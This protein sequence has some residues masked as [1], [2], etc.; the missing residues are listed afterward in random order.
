[1]S[2]FEGWFQL[3][4][5]QDLLKKLRHDLDRFEARPLDQYIAFDFFVTALHML[6]WRYPDPPDSDPAKKKTAKD[7]RDTLEDREILLR[8][9]SHLANG[10]KHFRATAPRHTSVSNARQ[11]AG[12][13]DPAVFDPT[14]FDAGE[15]VIDL[16]GEAARKFGPSISAL[17]VA[18]KLYQFWERTI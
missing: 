9:C 14:V 15:L 1:M 18:R 16:D 17:E 7:N 5:P 6:D 8:V 3:Q 12:A 2:S 10:G 11:T 4:T 13:F